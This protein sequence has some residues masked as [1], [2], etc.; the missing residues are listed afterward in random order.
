ML[1][2]NKMVSDL[3]EVTEILDNLFSNM[4]KSPET[5]RYEVG[6]ELHFNMN[7]DSTLKKNFKI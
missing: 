1:E 6:D 2:N 5:P 3:P 7:S 4:V